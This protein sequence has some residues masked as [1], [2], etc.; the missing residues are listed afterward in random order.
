MWI[1]RTLL[2]AAI[3]AG[4]AGVLATPA[5]AAP[6]YCLAGNFCPYDLPNLEVKMIQSHAPVGSKVD[7]QDDRTS[8][9]DNQTNNI[10]VGRNRR[11]ALP[12]GT[13]HTWNAG[14]TVFFLAEGDNTIDH[15]D[16]R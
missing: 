6:D 3:T 16:V 14:D 10:W 5:S 9:G 2:V 7:V 4:S 15:F 1:R 12:D 13:V 11:F 8:S